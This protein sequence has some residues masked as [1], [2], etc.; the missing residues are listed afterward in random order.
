MKMLNNPLS[1]SVAILALSYLPT[2]A[3]GLSWTVC[4]KDESGKQI[5]KDRVPRGAKIALALA[6]LAVLVLLLMLVVCICRNRRVAVAAEKEYNVEAS[7]VDGPPTIIATEYNP[8]SGPSRVYGA[9]KSGHL[10]GRFSPQPPVFPAT[11]HYQNYHPSAFTYQ[12][13]TAPV[14]QVAFPNP[15]YPFTGY[16]SVSKGC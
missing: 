1:A 2:P 7:Q 16:S 9:Q 11:V 5:C 12:N 14:T 3:A 8:T 4:A 13:Q 10:D 6:C 15:T